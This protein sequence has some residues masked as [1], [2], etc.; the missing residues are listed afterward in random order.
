MV[1]GTVWLPNLKNKKQ[2]KKNIHLRIQEKNISEGFGNKLNPFLLNEI[3]FSCETAFEVTG[4]FQ[5]AECLYMEFVPQSRLHNHFQLPCILDDLLCKL[6]RGNGYLFCTLLLICEGIIA[7]WAQT[8]SPLK[9]NMFE[10]SVYF[11]PYYSTKD[12][13][14]W[15]LDVATPEK[16]GGEVV[17]LY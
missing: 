2:T 9:L 17:K 3:L 12:E 14:R 7:V 11:S 5:W 4:L 15:K 8:P 1:S 6:L 16:A 10:I 13:D